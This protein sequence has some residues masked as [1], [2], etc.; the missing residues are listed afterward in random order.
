MTDV[1]LVLIFAGLG[2]IIIFKAS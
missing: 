1:I 2:A